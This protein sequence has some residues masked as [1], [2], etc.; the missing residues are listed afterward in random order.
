MVAK[1]NLAVLASQAHSAAI[2]T[3]TAEIKDRG[4]MPDATQTTVI[5]MADLL[6]A[7]LT[8]ANALAAIEVALGLV[9]GAAAP[10]QIKFHEETGLL[11][12]RGSVDQ[13]DKIRQVITQLRERQGTLEVREQN[14]E[15]SR[16]ELN[17]MELTAQHEGAA[18]QEA[19]MLAREVVEQRTRADLL[20][21]TV[22]DL[23]KRGAELEAELRKAAMEREALAH[24]V[25]ELRSQLTRESKP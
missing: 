11:I 16:R 9:E 20:Q 2:Y 23:R 15:A 1:V 12:A 19:Q 22:D 18:R 25:A 4:P 8:S 6:G 7:N 5:S 17:Q 21:Q 10:A 24:T 14:A 13:V 3:I